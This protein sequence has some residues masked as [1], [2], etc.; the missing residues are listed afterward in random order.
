MT[1]KPDELLALHKKAQ[2]LE[3]EANQ[4]FMSAPAIPLICK[5]GSIEVGK[6]A[7]STYDLGWGE[8]KVKVLVRFRR[9]EKP[10]TCAYISTRTFDSNGT[11]L[12]TKQNGSYVGPNGF[13]MGANK[14]VDI[15]LR[16]PWDPL[17][18]NTTAV[19][20]VEIGL[21]SFYN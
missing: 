8:I 5:D 7:K 4:L 10:H 13:D 9:W 11:L 3:R 17:K 12:E 16:I 2:S 21:D 15:E 14:P 19:E 18:P 6:I 1:K 20:Q